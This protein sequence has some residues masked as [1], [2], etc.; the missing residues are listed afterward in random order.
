MTVYSTL[1]NKMAFLIAFDTLQQFTAV[2]ILSHSDKKKKNL[3]INSYLILLIRGKGS[4]Y[5]MFKFLLIRRI[6]QKLTVILP[7]YYTAHP[8]PSIFKS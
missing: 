4:K 8:L 6:I 3:K 7:K 2:E 5:S 1:K